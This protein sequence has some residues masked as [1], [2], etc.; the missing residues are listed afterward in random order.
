VLQKGGAVGGVRRSALES[1][2]GWR[3]GAGAG[4]V[5]L[6]CRLL[7]K[8]WKTV[9]QNRS[10]CY[11]HVP[12][13]WAAHARRVTRWSWEYHHALACHAVALVRSRQ[14]SFRERW[15]GLLQLG[16][17]A[18]S[19]LLLVGW[20]LTLGFL[21]LGANPF[22]A[23]LALLVATWF[24]GL[25]DTPT[26]FEIAAAARLDGHRA[27]I[28]LLPLYLLCVFV[29]LV[30]VCGAAVTGPLQA[31]RPRSADALETHGLPKEWAL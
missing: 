2:G 11:E 15:D 26:L 5:D 7:L 23:L 30:A 8:G 14:V 27:R 31:W 13:N 22:P 17:Y 9:Y 18:A 25:G 20:L 1:I 10:E 21:Y 6:A 29:S 3:E 12:E 19:L 28:R 16:A 4:D 24:G